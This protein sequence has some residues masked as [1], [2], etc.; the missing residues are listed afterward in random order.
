MAGISGCQTTI[1][2]FFPNLIQDLSSQHLWQDS[3]DF[4]ILLAIISSFAMIFAKEEILM[5]DRAMGLLQSRLDEI[6]EMLQYIDGPTAR[7]MEQEMDRIQKII[8]AFRTN[9]ADSD[10]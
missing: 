2:Q 7:Q 4:R 9:N 5:I 8:D 10:S 3:T 1:L 6:R